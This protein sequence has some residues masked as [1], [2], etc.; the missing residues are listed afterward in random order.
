[1]QGACWLANKC[2]LPIVIFIKIRRYRHEIDYN[3]TAGADDWHA[4]Y[5]GYQVMPDEELFEAQP[6]Q[7]TVSMQKI[8]SQPGM[9]VRCERCGEEITNEREVRHVQFDRAC[10]RSLPDDQV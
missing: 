5:E 8:I 7:L 10:V 9:R 4:M 2:I 1:M 6:V 3:R